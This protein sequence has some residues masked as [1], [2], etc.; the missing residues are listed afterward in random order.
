MCAAHASEFNKAEKACKRPVQWWMRTP[1]LVKRARL[2]LQRDEQTGQALEGLLHIQHAF[3]DG[4]CGGGKI[5]E[6]PGGAVPAVVLGSGPR[7]KGWSGTEQ[8]RSSVSKWFFVFGEEQPVVLSNLQSQVR[9]FKGDGE[10]QPLVL[11]NLLLQTSELEN[12]GGVQSVVL[13]NLHSQLKGPRS[14]GEVQP[15]GATNLQSRAKLFKGAGEERRRLRPSLLSQAVLLKGDGEEQGV[16]GTSAALSAAAYF[17]PCKRA[18]FLLRRR[19]CRALVRGR[20]P[21]LRWF[22]ALGR[23][24]LHPALVR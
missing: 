19:W 1:G 24:S 8:V 22:Q 13:T 17:A 4:S 16:P 15:V 21:G 2:G 6:S 9:R 14:D 7:P 23:R 18:R 12:D 10:V 20:G 11:A 5:A 3:C